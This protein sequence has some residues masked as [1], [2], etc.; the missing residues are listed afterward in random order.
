MQ[1]GSNS[2]ST[3]NQSIIIP[4]LEEFE[5]KAIGE[6]LGFHQKE[7]KP[8]WSKPATTST[9]RMNSNASK[10][11]ISST[12]P[13]SGTISREQLGFLYNTEN[14]MASLKTN[15]QNKKAKIS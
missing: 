5:F 6:G 2:S 15:E 14:Q 11:V 12:L 7:E 10:V 9:S 3:N 13:S 4:D 1:I 8:R